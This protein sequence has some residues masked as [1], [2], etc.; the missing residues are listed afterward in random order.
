MLVFILLYLLYLWN[1]GG[2]LWLCDGWKFKHNIIRSHI[3][4]SECEEACWGSFSTWGNTAGVVY[5]ISHPQTIEVNTQHKPTSGLDVCCFQTA[6]AGVSLGALPSKW[7][8][9]LLHFLNKFLHFSRLSCSRIKSS[10]SK[11]TK[12]NNHIVHSN[13]NIALTRWSP[14]WW[15]NTK[16]SFTIVTFLCYVSLISLLPAFPLLL[17]L[18]QFKSAIIQLFT[19]HSK[20]YQYIYK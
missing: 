10:S 1:R 18:A 16:W 9:C 12:Q 13:N 8:D 2:W 5:K 19:Q 6:Q 11:L 4:T 17:C 7:V 20:L 14:T 3:H 15:M